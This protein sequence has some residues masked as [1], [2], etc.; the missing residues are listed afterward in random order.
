MKTLAAFASLILVPA[1]LGQLPTP[2]LDTVFPPGGKAGTEAIVQVSGTDLDG[3]R[4]LRFS[5]PGIT[6]APALLPAGAFWPEARVDGLKF[7]VVIGKDVPPAIYEVRTAGDD[8]LSTGRMFHVS[9][10]EGP[11]EILHPGA[12]HTAL[13]NPLPLELE[14]VV[15]GRV[16]AQ[17]SNYHRITLRRGERI[18]A[19]VM[20]TKLDSRLD[21]RIAILDSTGRELA[22]DR[23]TGERDPL[24]DFTAS[25]DGAYVVM[26]HD[27]LYRGG[28][29]YAY[30]LVVSRGPWVDAVFPLAAKLG[31]RQTFTVVGRNL[32]GGAPWSDPR[33]QS[34][35]VAVDLPAAP[36]PVALDGLKPGH[37][38]APR[39]ALS[40]PWGGT[41][42]CGITALPVVSEENSPAGAILQVPVEVSGTIAF[43]GNVDAFRFATK[44]GVT[45][46]VEA[47]S[48]RQG[49]DTDLALAVQRVNGE[50]LE[51]VAES[52]DL[53]P[54]ISVGLD[55]RIRDPGLT[56]KAAADGIYQVELRN[57]GD[58]YGPAQ[59]YRLVVREA[60]PGL[61]L[62]AA[63]ERSHLLLTQ[64]APGAPILAPGHRVGI[65]VIAVRSGGLTGPIRL[66]AKGLPPGVSAPPAVIWP[67]SQEGRIVL[68]AAPDAAPWQGN[69][70]I[71][72]ECAGVVQI[73][74]GGIL[75]WGVTD[76]TKERTS[77]RL[78]SG[79]PL[80][81][82][83]A[84]VPRLRIDVVP[85]AGQIE[86]GKDL[87]F[88]IKVER[89]GAVKGAITVTPSGLPGFTKP[90]TVT[91]AEKDSEASLKV[92]FRPDNINRPGEGNGTVVFLASAIAPAYRSHPENVAKLEAWKGFQDAAIAKLDAK[93]ADAQKAG[94]AARAELTRLL[95]VAKERAKERELPFTVTSAPVDLTV[96][97][98]AKKKP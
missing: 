82:C 21:A 33:W 20:A 40:L 22:A 83:A 85:E 53:F 2:T 4:S 24:L 23:T 39:H 56:F 55:T 41:F 54:T 44:A 43:P 67:Q 51:A 1:L 5:H 93:D 84:E 72:G 66:T 87:T 98:P 91:I 47:I 75:K 68:E 97:D 78:S 15:T 95:T 52:D 35:S 10:P 25:A 12:P 34:L 8:G 65:R 57:L 27:L 96:I 46:E 71:T 19:K 63:Q 76:M 61:T 88:K 38:I 60:S 42:P 7:R 74:V 90:P 50:K 14:Q 89:K 59:G 81:V 45:Y 32:P 58:S 94:A 36:V 48:Y 30:R 79:I 6:G 69:I 9:A 77:S 49:L 31:T 16:A 3:V 18:I 86:L 11:P 73:A 80:A 28:D 92:P 37:A 26:V 64:A 13:L 29:P 62:F 17:Q 70:E